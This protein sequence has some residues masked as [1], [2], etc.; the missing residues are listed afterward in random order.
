MRDLFFLALLPLMLYL[1]ACRPFI[2][3]GM[4]IWTALFFPNAWMYGVASG[5]RY[6][7]IFT[8]IAILGYMV[9]KD[10]PKV[11]F[12]ALGGLVFLFFLWTT[13]S[14]LM[15]EGLVE[16][17]WDIWTRF[18]KVILLFVFVVLIINKKLHI[19]FFLGCV[20]LSVGFFGS[21]EG[22]KFIASGGGHHIE[23]F[24]GHALGDRNELALAFVITLPICFYL[25]NQY[26]QQSRLVRLA[27]F[28]VIGLLVTSIVGTQSRGGF[29][30]LLGL[31]GYL[32][33]KSERKILLGILIVLL[34][35]ALSYVVSD[36]WTSR[37]NTINEAGEDASFMGRVVAWKLS[38]IQAMRHPFFGGG[39][40]SL[41]YFPVWRS[42]SSEF[43]S[44]AFFYTGD[45][46]PDEHKAHAAH[47]VY[48]QVL[49][50]HGFGGLAI[51]L[52]MLA[53]AFLNARRLVITARKQVETEWIAALGVMIQLCIFA[54]CLGGAA[55]SFAYF[56]LMYALYG[57]LLVLETRL[58]PEALKAIAA[59]P[60]VPAGPA[61][62]PVLQPA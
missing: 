53:R 28:G 40:K 27:L 58:L 20:V 39:F 32:F 10:K 44:Y 57:V 46:L 29:V 2:A 7:L 43:F 41:E 13:G 56:E 60:A 26:G 37:M 15:T 16:V 6:N 23:G 3:L 21:L 4:W 38:F 31:G 45:A 49:G 18:F 54:F 48:F 50:E 22:L 30:A 51:Y 61:V 5:I 25:L 12:G 47:S 14:T 62:K 35:G 59:A 34:V 42:L 52:A 17:G 55:L 11:R 24:Y 1:M 19:D 33:L 8:A 36:D 9:L